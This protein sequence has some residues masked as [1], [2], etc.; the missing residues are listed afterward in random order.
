MPLK[1][2]CPKLEDENLE[3]GIMSQWMDV[4]LYNNHIIGAVADDE[5]E[6]DEDDM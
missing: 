3:V 5:E 4:Q 1:G 2:E 6:D